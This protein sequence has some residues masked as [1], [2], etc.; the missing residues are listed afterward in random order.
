MKMDLAFDELTL[1]QEKPSLFI[2]SDRD[3]LGICG[4]C[5]I[6]KS[7]TFP[8]NKVI[9]EC[10][11]WVGFKPNNSEYK[12]FNQDTSLESIINIR[13]NEQNEEPLRGLCRYCSIKSSCTFPKK[14]GGIWNCDEYTE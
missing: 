13:T 10:D 11:E 8:R 6:S 14:E 12:Q 5:S 3:K 7:C 1:K 9:N 4:N 2:V